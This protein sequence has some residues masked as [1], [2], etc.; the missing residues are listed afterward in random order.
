MDSFS[1]VSYGS[2]AMA[3]FSLSCTSTAA[4]VVAG[5]MGGGECSL[6]MA[7]SA[8]QSRQSGIARGVLIVLDCIILGLDCPWG[9]SV[10]HDSVFLQFDVAGGAASRCA[11]VAVSP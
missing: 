9:K 1:L 10:T 7:G 5:A 8:S 4:K 3:T 2:A 6:A 11:L